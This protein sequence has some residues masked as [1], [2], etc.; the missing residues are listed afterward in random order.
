MDYKK[1]ESIVKDWAGPGELLLTWKDEKGNHCNLWLELNDGEF[2][3]ESQR[4][5]AGE[6]SET[7]FNGRYT[8]FP[9]LS[10]AKDALLSFALLAS[11]YY[12]LHAEAME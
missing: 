4:Y 3:I 6:S 2:V 10:T 8:S 7:D 9:D 11:D 5:N 1:I 12:T